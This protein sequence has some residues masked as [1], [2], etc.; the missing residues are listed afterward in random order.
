[1]TAFLLPVALFLAVVFAVS[2]IGK[3]RSPDRGRGTF[4]ALRIPVSRTGTASTALIL[5]EA[6]VAVALVVTTGWLFVAAA[7]AAL[8]LTSALLMVVIRAHRLG[9]AE[10]CGCFGEWLPAVIGPR[11]IVRNAV[12][13]TAAFFLFLPALF[14][15][16][17]T[18]RPTGVPL[19]LSSG[20]AANSSLGALA[21]A[22]LIAFGVW[23]IARAS[24]TAPAA[25]SPI[26]RGDGAVLVPATSE[27]VDVLARGSRARLLVFVSAGCHACAT[28]LDALIQDQGSLDSL[29]EIY[30]IQ[31][32][33]SGSAVTR[34]TH[35]LPA[36]AR[37]ALDIG[38]SL[39]GALEIGTARPAAA[40]IGTDGAQAGPLA[41]GSEEIAQLVASIV[42]F[43][44]EPTA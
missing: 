28:A 41:L 9:A 4:E 5:L 31:R 1:M 2:A 44:D 36:T 27:V 17:N 22:T 30:V 20:S 26:A 16:A 34:P 21:A 39:G 8:L 19:L 10:D 14:L 3:L 35:D 29:V 25:P 24:S 23:S 43:A 12:L 40:L 11:L 38:G 15:L 13:A 37:F 42:A 33:S 32:A 18:G 6:L 7:G